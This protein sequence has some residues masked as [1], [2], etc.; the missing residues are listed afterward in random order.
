MIKDIS[1][2]QT[3]KPVLGKLALL[4]QMQEMVELGYWGDH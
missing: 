1:Q 3:Q 4:R 2:V